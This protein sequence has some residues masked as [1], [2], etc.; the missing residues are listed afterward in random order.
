MVLAAGLGQRLRPITATLPKP[1]IKVGG[2]ALIDYSLDRL[3]DAGITRAVVNVHHL[4]DQVEA[5]LAARRAP[6]IAISDERSL[7]L[8]T[9]GG[10]KKARPLLGEEPFLTLNSDSLWVEGSRPNLPRLIEEWDPDRMD[11]LMLVAAAISRWTRMDAC[12]AGASGRSR[13]SCLR[14]CRS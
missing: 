9:G 8:E 3:A 2:R 11:I 13:P 7:L 4:A 6:A 5:H 1:L 10:L 12:G 14:A